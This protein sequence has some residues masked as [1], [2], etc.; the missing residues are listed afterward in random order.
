MARNSQIM[1]NWDN[2]WMFICICVEYVE[3]RTKSPYANE[4]GWKSG[5]QEP[6]GTRRLHLQRAPKSPASGSGSFPSHRPPS[7]SWKLAKHSGPVNQER[8]PASTL[9]PPP[10]K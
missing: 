8:P 1:N 6:R 9:H 3:K 5:K 7:S 10:I 2:I 4:K